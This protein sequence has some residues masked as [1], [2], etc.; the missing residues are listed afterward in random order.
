MNISPGLYNKIVRSKQELYYEKSLIDSVFDLSNKKILDFG[1]GTGSQAVFFEPKLYYGVDID[2][3][4]IQ[5]ARKNFPKHLFFLQNENKIKFED[6][7][8]DVILAIA[9]LH[10]ISDKKLSFYID[11]FCRILKKDGVIISVEPCI[12]PKSNLRNKL[13]KFFDQGKFIRTEKEY[14]SFFDKRFLFS[15][16]KKF[17]TKKNFFNFYNI[18]FFSAKKI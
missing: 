13:M 15:T 1:C 6:N 14:K 2:E 4:R 3:K 7:F 5:A 18:I 10:H 17:E 8:F 9:V 16:H 12:F 11:E